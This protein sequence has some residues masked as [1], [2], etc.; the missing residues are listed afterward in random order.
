M[1]LFLKKAPPQAIV[2]PQQAG[3]DSL[4]AKRNEQL[5][6]A[7]LDVVREPS[8]ACRR[9]EVACQQARGDEAVRDRNLRVFRHSCELE[10]L[11]G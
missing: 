8:P 9:L 2:A 11:L 10:S 4:R 5:R 1:R 6:M 3:A 7:L